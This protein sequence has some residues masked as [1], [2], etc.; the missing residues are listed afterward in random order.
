[1]LMFYE[2]QKYLYTLHMKRNSSLRHKSPKVY[3]LKWNP[4]NPA[5]SFPIIFMKGIYCASQISRI[6]PSYGVSLT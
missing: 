3:A 4:R 6:S 5:A 1:M 2:I